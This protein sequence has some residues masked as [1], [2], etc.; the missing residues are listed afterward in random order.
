MEATQDELRQFIERAEQI[1]AEKADLAETAKELH[2]EV[3]GRGYD[4]KAFK[5]VLRLRKMTP[6]ARAEFEAIVS[7]YR[8]AAGL[9]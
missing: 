8:E 1:A 3:K 6:D 7:M 9:A 4:L 2:A 5:E